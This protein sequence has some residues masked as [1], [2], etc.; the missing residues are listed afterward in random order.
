M[1]KYG[2]GL[3]MAAF[4]SVAVSAYSAD[5]AKEVALISNP[6]TAETQLKML[7]DTKEA[8]LLV[9]NQK[10]AEVSAAN[11]EKDLTISALRAQASDSASKLVAL[12]TSVEVEVFK[13]LAENV[14][15]VKL[16]DFGSVRL[17]PLLND[18]LVIIPPELSQKV[19][20]F[21]SKIQKR[22]LHGKAGTYL[23]CDRKY[24]VTAT[25]QPDVIQKGDKL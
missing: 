15:N 23:I 13:L 10:N 3:L 19:D 8:E 22:I 14:S 5:E 4:L 24:F 18:Y 11:A 7:V 25:K 9:L 2:V 1:K 17:I 16:R 21:F 20:F 12:Q 6:Q